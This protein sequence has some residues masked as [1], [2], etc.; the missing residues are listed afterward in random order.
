MP[1]GS[2]PERWLANIRLSSF[3]IMIMLL[4]VVGVVVL[5]PSLKLLIEQKQQIAALQK[6]VDQQ[7]QDVSSLKT[8]VGRWSDPAYIEAQARNRLLFVEPGEYSF[9]VI[10]TTSSASTS[11]GQPISKHLQTTRVDWVKSLTGSLFTAG[12]SNASATTLTK[13][14][15]IV[16]PVVG[17]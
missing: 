1:P 6:S 13:G 9:L 4:V 15:T 8:Q 7:K 3:T 12:L 11:N 17:G 16:S 5:A 10:P 2:A 14:S